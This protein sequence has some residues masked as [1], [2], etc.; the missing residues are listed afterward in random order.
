MLARV[1]SLKRICYY[2]RMTQ[3]VGILNLTPDS[4]SDGGQYNSLEA[5]AARTAQLFEDGAA[6]VDMGAESTNP[7]S[8]PIALEEEWRRLF[9]VLKRLLELYTPQK[10]SVDSFHPETVR[11][12]LELGPVIINDLTGMNNPA[13]VDL[14]TGHGATCIVSHLQ[15]LNPAGVHSQPLIDDLQ[16]IKDDLLARARMLESRGLSRDRIILDPGIGFGKTPELNRRLLRFAE[17]VPDYQV[18]I[19]YSRKRFLG[20]QRMEI[21][22]NLE[23]GRV[24]IESGAAYLRV[25]DVAAHRELLT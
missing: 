22:P 2:G 10:L 11:Q 1:S 20:S 4:F 13:M 23:A 19:G 9:P 8:T 7:H 18:M 6:I 5:A 12:V 21:E 24:A 3:L 17:E 14:V 16:V 15:G 25:H